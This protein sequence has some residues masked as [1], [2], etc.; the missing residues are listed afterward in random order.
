MTI[1]IRTIVLYAFCTL[2]SYLA[3]VYFG[4]ALLALFYLFLLYPVV[5]ILL[6]VH[7]F[8]S[9]EFYQ[10][11]G[12]LEAVRGQPVDYWVFLRNESP[13]PVHRV[14]VRFHPTDPQV[15][16][17]L[18][19][20]VLSLGSRER[21]ERRF[22]LRFRHCGIFPIGVMNVEMEDFLRF[23][24][25]RRKVAPRYCSILP[26]IHELRGFA[27]GADFLRGMTTTRPAASESDRAFFGWLREY[28]SGEPVHDI[29]WKKFAATG[30]PYLKEYE[31]STGGIARI[32][33][34]L[35]ESCDQRVDSFARQDGSLE[36]LVAVVKYLLDRSITTAV[37]APGD[38]PYRFEGNH[39]GCFRLL[40]R[41][42]PSLS[43]HDAPSPA[44]LYLLDNKGGGSIHSSVI[45]I[46]HRIDAAL[47]SVL[48]SM[49]RSRVPVALLLN[50]IGT[51]PDIRQ[52]DRNLL[53]TVH[54]SEAKIV[55][56]EDQ[57]MIS[58]ALEGV[59]DVL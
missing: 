23:L 42:V 30:K 5:S 51:P 3:G 59:Y 18:P 19:S 24:T 52:A 34:D 15:E 33:F 4:A 46:V 57:T 25:L 8:V 38:P 22:R 48:E 58:R 44:R 28:R 26:R 27:L 40:Y 2:L 50:H 14:V 56:I 49:S 35:R 21:P 7:N 6:L 10:V 20:L 29:S 17:M 31:G 45:F 55:R 37:L 16:E 43:F 54:R 39:P 47:T 32:Y 9:L 12:S 36:V 11:L 53:Q 41:S 1:H 13:V